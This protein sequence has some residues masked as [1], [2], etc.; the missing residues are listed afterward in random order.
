MALPLLIRP[1]LLS[2]WNITNLVR[3]IDVSSN[4]KFLMSLLC[5]NFKLIMNPILS[6]SRCEFCDKCYTKKFT[7]QCHT[8]TVHIKDE[9]HECTICKKGFLSSHALNNHIRKVHTANPVQ[10]SCK[11]CKKQFKYIELL[12]THGKV[13]LLFFTLFFIQYS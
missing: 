6:I 2:Y 7:L 10:Y 11:I 9:Y 3:Y 8:K 4:Y 12:R 13:F 5:E 1:F